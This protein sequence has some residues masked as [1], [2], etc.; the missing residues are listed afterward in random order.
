M[1]KIMGAT[2]LCTPMEV[3]LKLSKSEMKKVL[4]EFSIEVLLIVLC[5]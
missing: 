5:T 3:A 1:F 4:I 2:P